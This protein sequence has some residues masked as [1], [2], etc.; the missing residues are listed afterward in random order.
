LLRDFE[1]VK[2]VADLHEVTHEGVTGKTGKWVAWLRKPA[3][4]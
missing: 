3:A 1:I 2:L 4:T